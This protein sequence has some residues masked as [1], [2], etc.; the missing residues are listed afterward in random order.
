MILKLEGYVGILKLGTL[1]MNVNRLLLR[2]NHFEGQFFVL[3]FYCLVIFV[4][5]FL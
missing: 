3:F 5:Q 2:I 1:F 4:E